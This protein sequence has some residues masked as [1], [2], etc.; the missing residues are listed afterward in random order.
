MPVSP[1]LPG[2]LT[3]IV[4]HPVPSLNALF[5][6]THWQRHR[7]KRATLDALLSALS[8]SALDCS[9]PTTWWEDR[10]ILR[11]AYD[12]LALYRAMQKRRS[13]L[14]SDRKRSKPSKTN[15]PASK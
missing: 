15:T 14:K 3:L 1:P 8:P 12:T 5:A 10:S 9:M 11:T 2:T 7:E 4:H 6:M 13:A